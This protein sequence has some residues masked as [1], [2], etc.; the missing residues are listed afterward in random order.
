M[1]V[2]EIRSAEVFKIFYVCIRAGFAFFS[3]SVSVRF[4]S[5][6]RTLEFWDTGC[7]EAVAWI[8]AVN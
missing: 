2:N 6:N 7:I 8:Q 5:F 1:S 3:H 4:S